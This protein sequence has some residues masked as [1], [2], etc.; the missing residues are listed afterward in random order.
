ME[1]DVIIREKIDE[2]QGVSARTNEQYHVVTFLGETEEYSPQRI[3]FEVWDGRDGRIA[4]LNIQAGKK[5]KLFLN[6]EA[7]QHEGKWYNQIRAWNA[8]AI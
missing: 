1:I 5:Y 6:F 3:V 7:R 2:R 4:R 8:R